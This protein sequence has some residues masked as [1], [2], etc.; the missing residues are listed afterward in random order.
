MRFF[1]ELF[2][3]PYLISLDILPKDFY[4]LF[5]LHDSSP[6]VLFSISYILFQILC[7]FR[8]IGHRNEFLLLV[9]QAAYRLDVAQGNE[10]TD[11]YLR[12]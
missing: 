7:V 4:D 11:L 9:V 2:K 1:K 5:D 12:Q 10:T 3:S 8:F 6:T